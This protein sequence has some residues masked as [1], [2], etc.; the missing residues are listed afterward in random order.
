M[1]TRLKR[2]KKTKFEKVE[3]S[4]GKISRELKNELCRIRDALQSVFNLLRR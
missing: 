3:E 1:G 2:K 4:K